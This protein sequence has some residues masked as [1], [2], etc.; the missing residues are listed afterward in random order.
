MNKA[1]LKAAAERFK[2]QS[3]LIKAATV[4]SLFGETTEQQE[5]RIK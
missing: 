2:Q 5:R 3:K 1:D 4:N